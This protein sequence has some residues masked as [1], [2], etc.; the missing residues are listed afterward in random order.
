MDHKQIEA[1]YIGYPKLCPAPAPVVSGTQNIRQSRAEFYPHPNQRRCGDA[2][3]AFHSDAMRRSPTFLRQHR[4]DNT[5]R[6]RQS[7][8]AHGTE[9]HLH[10]YL[11][12][13]HHYH[14]GQY[15]QGAKRQW[16]R[17]LHCS[18]LARSPWPSTIRRP[19]MRPLGKDI[20]DILYSPQGACA[21][22]FVP[23][24]SLA[25]DRYSTD[26]TDGVD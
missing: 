1:L 20:L 25:S 16:P 24:A 18:R 26:L 17:S 19:P 7:S 12:S 9:R 4:R 22:T 21:H 23:A 13:R 15:R 11:S 3:M 8:L 5:Q 6:V 10:R 2:P 14:E